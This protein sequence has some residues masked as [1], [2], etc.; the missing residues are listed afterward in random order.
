VRDVIRV[1]SGNCCSTTAINRLGPL[2]RRSIASP[3]TCRQKAAAPGT[4]PA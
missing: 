4:E 1:L 2:P 3:L